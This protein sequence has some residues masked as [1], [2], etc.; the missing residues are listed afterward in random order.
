MKRAAILAILAVLLPSACGDPSF[1]PEACAA[2]NDTE[3]FIGEE[4]LVVLCFTDPDGD[5]VTATATASDPSVVEA[6]VQGGAQAVLLTGRDAGQAVITVVAQDSRGASA[7]PQ[8]FEVTVPN[9]AP[10]AAALPEITLTNDASEASL[11]L[12]E[13]FTDPDGHPLTFSAAVS[14]ETVIRATVTGSILEIE[15]TGDGPAGHG[16]ATVRVTATDPHGASASA[17]AEVAIRVTTEILRDEFDTLSDSWESYNAAAEV[18][19]GW[20][21]L[22][23]DFY[24]GL[25]ALRHSV[26]ESTDWTFEVSTRYNSDFLWPSILIVTDTDP[27]VI[28]VLVGGDIR[29]LAGD[30]GLAETNLAIGL[31]SESAG[32]WVS[33]P[34]S[35][36]MYPQIA[37]D[38]AMDVGVRL[39]PETLTVVV[40]G[41][42]IHTQSRLLER[43]GLRMP[44]TI[45]RA[46]LVAWVPPDT[47]GFQGS[48]VTLFDWIRVTGTPSGAA[49]VAS[50]ARPDAP[51]RLLPRPSRIR[52]IHR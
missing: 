4:E 38:T 2:L 43:A 32:G 11:T 21:H 49:S 29:L 25:A 33:S 1:P 42:E 10:E 24:S 50:E 30:P 13:Y 35:V 36:G 28:A 41:T 44:G 45:T 14:D 51:G 23:P 37:K 39:G 12:T 5:A 3:V 26:P 27:E 52:M 40:D 18:V 20:L 31:F 17:D 7:D 34:E 22:R 15:A 47:D 6:V 46:E 9:R 8:A 48:E 19:S 16:P